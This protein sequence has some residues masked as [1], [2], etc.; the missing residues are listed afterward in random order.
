MTAGRQPFSLCS[1]IHPSLSVKGKPVYSFHPVLML[2][3]F[4]SPTL[5]PSSMVAVVSRSVGPKGSCF[6]WPSM[7]ITSR[8]ISGSGAP[9]PP[10]AAPP[11]ASDDWSFSASSSGSFLI[12]S[13]P[14]SPSGFPSASAFS[15]SSSVF[16]FLI[17]KTKKSINGFFIFWKSHKLQNF[18]RLF[19]YL[20][21]ESLSALS[22]SSSS[23]LPRLLLDLSY[24]FGNG[25]EDGAFK[26]LLADVVQRVG[27]PHCEAER[28]PLQGDSSQKH[29]SLIKALGNGRREK[30]V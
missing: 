17:W 16:S 21:E 24:I 12:C 29:F 5:S 11:P 20:C 22:S 19:L 6:C 3:C 8:P 15:P 2:V 10:A 4:E 13:F 18:S 26:S 27:V 9:S 1:C 28:R 30:R 14:S 23:F 7:V 25:F